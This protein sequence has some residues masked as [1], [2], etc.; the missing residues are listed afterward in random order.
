MD[1]VLIVGASSDIGKAVVPLLDRPG[2][3]ILAHYHESLH[4]VESLR[5]GLRGELLPIGADLAE[6]E[7]V[8]GLIGQAMPYEPDK[9]LFLAA[10]RIAA[11]RFRQLTWDDFS[12]QLD[13]GLRSTVSIL[14]AFLPEMAKKKSGKVVLMLTS[15]TLNVPPAVFA[16][17]VTAKYALLGLVKALSS[18][19][20][21]HGI[22]INAVSPSMV[23]TEFLRDLPDK[24]IEI[25]AEQHP[26]GRN[27][28]PKD[29]AP[30][31]DFLLSS[32]SDFMTGLNIPVSGGEVF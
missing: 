16:H 25:A 8:Q 32:G 13:V 2:R 20:R 1:N 11:I 18:E 17:Y 28:R 31:I 4:K 26:A 19:Y 27:A 3:T 5:R 7:Q 29:I 21:R 24:M 15:S 12:Y 10:P 23:E 14:Q 22:N 30:I 6:V 9:I